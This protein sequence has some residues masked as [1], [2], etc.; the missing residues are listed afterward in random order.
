MKGFLFIFLLSISGYSLAELPE[1]MKNQA[2]VDKFV[3]NSTKPFN[4]KDL[5]KIRTYSSLIKEEVNKFN[6]TISGKEAKRYTFYFQGLKIIGFFIPGKWFF[7][8]YVEVSESWFVL[9][10]GIKIGSTEQELINHFKHSG[11]M[12]DNTITYNGETENVIF[13]LVNGI[14]TKVQIYGYTG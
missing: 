12:K 4:T 5:D 14:V 9:V 7:L 13:T 1:W 11:K 8:E 2:I 6:E 3:W 10:G